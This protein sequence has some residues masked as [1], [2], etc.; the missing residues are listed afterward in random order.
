MEVSDMAPIKGTASELSAVRRWACNS[1]KH[2]CFSEMSKGASE[3]TPS[4]ELL[5]R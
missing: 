2:H 3:E 5:N 1:K 4:I